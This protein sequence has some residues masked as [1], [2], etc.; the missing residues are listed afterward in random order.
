MLEEGQFGN[1]G[2]E[3]PRGNQ[4]T[5]SWDMTCVEGDE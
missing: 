2:Q 5:G 3:D 4:R 1:D